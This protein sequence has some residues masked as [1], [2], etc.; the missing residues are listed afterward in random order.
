MKFCVY[1]A[2]VSAVQMSLA[3]HPL[4]MMEDDST[5]GDA[6]HSDTVF[7]C[8][9]ETPSVT[10]GSQTALCCG[11][12]SPA[13]TVNSNASGDTCTVEYRDKDGIEYRITCQNLDK[14]DRTCQCQ[15]IQTDD[16]DSVAD[17]ATAQPPNQ[18]QPGFIASRICKTRSSSHWSVRV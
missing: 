15:T 4:V 1:I 16:R 7:D 17:R 8:T 2:V 13:D 18:K 5:E 12:P 10:C 11:F 6:A 14:D 3:C 9:P